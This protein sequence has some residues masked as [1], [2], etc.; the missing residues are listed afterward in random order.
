LSGNDQITDTNWH[1]KPNRQWTDL[2]EGSGSASPSVPPAQQPPPSHTPAYTDTVIIEPPT[3]FESLVVTTR[4]TDS[5]Y[6]QHH[7]PTPVRDTDT[8]VNPMLIVTPHPRAASSS[9]TPPLTKTGGRVGAHT[10]LAVSLV[11][12]HR[13]M[14]YFVN[15]S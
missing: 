7:V 11:I 6:P 12:V 15:Y 3:E 10:V 5:I 8:V 2:S 9:P 14:L 4:S 13:S 1:L